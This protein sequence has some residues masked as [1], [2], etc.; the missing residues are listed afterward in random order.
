[1]GRRRC[2]APQP[3][4]GD[5]AARPGDDGRQRLAHGRRR[6]DA[7]WR[8]GLAC[9]AV[10][11]VVRQRRDVHARHG[12][13]P[14]PAGEQHGEPG[15]LLGAARRRRQLRCRD[16]VRV[17]APPHDGARVDRGPL[18]RPRPAG[19]S[20]CDARLAR[21]PAR[22]AASSHVDERRDDRRRRPVPARVAARTSGCHRRLRVGRRDGGRAPL[23]RRF[24]ADRDAGR[25]VRGRDALHRPPEHRR[26][27]APPRSAALL[28]GPLP[29][30]VD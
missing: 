24:P 21:P 11:P 25:G 3:R 29:D 12:G 8:D 16:R 4:P 13:W 7:R 20:G 19:G 17:P 6:A 28:G 15:P 2:A 14:D 23:P 30:R 27:A 9:P 5:R 26:R 1:M 10:R 18:L 22:R